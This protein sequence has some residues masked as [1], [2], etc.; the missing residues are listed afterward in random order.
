MESSR[1]IGSGI[2]GVLDVDPAA[3][4]AR[5]YGQAQFMESFPVELEGLLV[6]G[7]WSLLIKEDDCSE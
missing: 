6:A 4:V 3:Q 7:C 1:I 2:A 5:L